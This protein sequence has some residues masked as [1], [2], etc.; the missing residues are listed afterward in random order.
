VLFRSHTHLD[1]KR[2]H[3]AFTVSTTF[4]LN[5]AEVRSALYDVEQLKQSALSQVRK[6]LRH[7]LDKLAFERGV[8]RGRNFFRVLDCELGDL[9]G[10]NVLRL[11]D[12][13]KVAFREHNR[14]HPR[15]SRRSLRNRCRLLCSRRGHPVYYVYYVLGTGLDYHYFAPIAIGLMIHSTQPPFGSSLLIKIAATSSLHFGQT[16]GHLPS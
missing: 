15:M 6:S 9:V 10:V 8:H 3:T 13:C 5:R 7:L 12:Q 14:I 1:A 16:I 2:R 11:G 4:D